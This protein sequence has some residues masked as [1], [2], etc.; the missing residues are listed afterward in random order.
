MIRK[1]DL[2]KHTTVENSYET[3]IVMDSA[4]IKIVVEPDDVALETTL[5]LANKIVANFSKYKA[6]AENKIVEV[7][8]DNYNENW[9][10]NDHPTLSRKQFIQNLKLDRMRFLSDASVDFFYQENGMFGNHSLIAQSFDGE[11]FEDAIM[12]G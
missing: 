9:V 7:F 5:V 12:Y 6:N 2:T 3:S 10:D 4:K 11:N 1:E 8:L